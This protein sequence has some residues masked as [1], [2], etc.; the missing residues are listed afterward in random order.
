[1][2]GTDAALTFGDLALRG[3]VDVR[4][5][6]KRADLERR[7]FVL[8]GSRVDLSAVAFTGH[9]GQA[10][11]GWWTQIELDQARIDLDDPLTARGRARV[12]MSDAGFLLALYARDR[13]FPAWVEKIVDAGE[14]AASG[15]LGWSDHTLVVDDLV[16]SND[17]FELR[18]RMRMRGAQREGSLYAR[19]GVLSL[20]A[21]LTGHHKDLHLIGA[22]EWY[23]AQPRLL[24]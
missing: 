6:L 8:D 22:R 15:E 18:A 17:R 1:V 16:A 11:D 23:D 9:G 14:V 12:R 3:D 13:S 20:G 21:E 5:Q 19:W 7:R 4:T 10:R 2:R 24:H